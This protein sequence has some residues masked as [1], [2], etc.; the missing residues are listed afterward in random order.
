MKGIARRYKGAQLFSLRKRKR[1]SGWPEIHVLKKR[2][3]AVK[4]RRRDQVGHLLYA[5]SH[6]T[7]KKFVD[8][9]SEGEKSIKELSWLVS[10]S[11]QAISAHLRILQEAGLL[12]RARRNGLVYCSLVKGPLKSVA[13]WLDSG[14]LKK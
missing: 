14:F 2:S 3:R 10:Q 6:P 9:L 1:A 5:V 7:R 8:A 11:A 13:Q 4:P 12:Q